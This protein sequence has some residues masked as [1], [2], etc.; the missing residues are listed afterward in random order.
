MRGFDT[1]ALILFPKM[2]NYEYKSGDYKYQFKKAVNNLLRYLKSVDIEPH[3][4]YTDDVARELSYPDFVWVSTLCTADRYFIANNCDN[5]GDALKKNMITFDDI[6]N[7]I[8]AK[9]PGSVFMSEQE[10][11]EMV[12]RHSA[13]A[14]SKIIPDY[15]IVIHIQ[16]PTKAQYKVTSKPNDGKIRISVS[17]NTFA[18]KA[19]LSGFEED[20]CD[21]LGIPYGNRTLDVWG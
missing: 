20:A 12:I 1:K 18:P 13:K 2:E 15:K 3:V 4:F 16:L 6:Y 5:C 8:V 11:Y 10:R 19:Y 14:A 17:A 21:L 9:D 7:E